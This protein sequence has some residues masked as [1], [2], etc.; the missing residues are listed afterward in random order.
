MT[1]EVTVASTKGEVGTTRPGRSEGPGKCSWTGPRALDEG[2]PIE[3]TPMA[4]PIDRD[5]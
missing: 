3:P 1:T 4:V 2:N 5:P